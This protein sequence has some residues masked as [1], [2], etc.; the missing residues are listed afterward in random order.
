MLWT[1]LPKGS[2]GKDIGLITGR[3]VNQLTSKINGGT[4]VRKSISARFCYSDFTS[5]QRRFLALFLVILRRILR[6]TT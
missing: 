4:G 2:F 3:R 6:N 5:S 1:V